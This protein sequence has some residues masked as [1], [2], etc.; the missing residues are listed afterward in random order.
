MEL[1]FMEKG[2][3]NEA[4]N[5]AFLIHSIRLN[6]NSNIVDDESAYELEKA[7]YDISNID[8]VSIEKDLREDWKKILGDL[9]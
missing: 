6:D 5:I 2:M 7:G 8:Y 1:I 3:E 4:Q 9:E